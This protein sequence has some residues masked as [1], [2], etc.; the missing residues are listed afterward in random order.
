M[1]D[2][3]TDAVLY[4]CYRWQRNL[5]MFVCMYMDM[6]VCMYML[7]MYIHAVYVCLHVPS[8]VR[9]LR[10][11]TYTIHV[12]SIYINT[13]QTFSFVTR[14]LGLYTQLMCTTHALS[15]YTH[16]HFKANLVVC[17]RWPRS[18]HTTHV[19]YTC[20]KHVHTSTHASRSE[21]SLL[22]TVTWTQCP[23]HTLH[24]L[25][26]HTHFAANLLICHLWPWSL[27]MTHVYDT[28]IISTYTYTHTFRSEPSHLSTAVSAQLRPLHTTPPSLQGL[29]LWIYLSRTATVSYAIW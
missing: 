16:T 10:T 12:L 23:I 1:Y 24:V 13:Q 3:V 2:V 7:C 11:I 26:I 5:G 6:Y 29:I 27:H 25:C 19:Y 8:W 20:V 4:G 14:G 17:H 9:S 18:L 15:T 22:C 28:C 21:P